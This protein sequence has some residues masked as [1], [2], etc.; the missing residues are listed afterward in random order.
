[1]RDPIGRVEVSVDS[2]LRYAFAPLPE[3]HFLDTLTAA[4][5]VKRGLLT[6]FAFESRSL[7]RARKVGFATYPWE[8]TH[9]QLLQA[10]F[11][12]L[13][14][15]EAA[16]TEGHELK[17]AS[18]FNVLFERDRPEFCDHFSMQPVQRRQWWAYGQFLRHFLFPLAVSRHLGMEPADVFKASLDGLSLETT[19]ALLGA[20]RWTSRIGLALLQRQSHHGGSKVAVSP[21]RENS[22]NPLHQRLIDFL[23][24]QLSELEQVPR[25]SE[26]ASYEE[27][28]NHYSSISIE[29]K[30]DIVARW[31]SFAAPRWVVDLGCNQGEFSFVAAGIAAVGVI[32]VDADMA[33]IVRL[34]AKL[35]AETPIYT[36]C[37]DLDDLPRGR[38]WM[39][40]EYPGL[41]ERLGAQADVTMALALVHHLVIG[42]SIP[43]TEV[44][45]LMAA[46][47]RRYLIVE[48]LE[49]DD[50]MVQALLL[51]RDRTDDAGFTLED[52]RRAFGEQFQTIEEIVLEGSSRRLVLLEKFSP[53]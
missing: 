4:Q 43:L 1:M 3:Y 50:P 42:R 21:R 18:A 46:S 27:T 15:A 53:T 30:R 31:L 19:R 8:W 16:L 28:R 47:T 17:D 7:V 34:R 11:T 24:W 38:G 32:A 12:T 2:I 33:A 23:R 22:P 20:K 48:Y 45:A 37:A 5:L 29:Y 25:I 51:S 9:G 13:D 35:N 40:R 49:A 14:V 41:L 44:A 26:W 6:P 10:A 39:G 36:I 52:Q